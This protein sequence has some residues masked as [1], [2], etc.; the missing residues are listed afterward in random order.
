MAKLGRDRNRL[1]ILPG[2]LVVVGDTAEEA[3][4]KRAR[5]DGLVNY[6]LTVRELAQRLGG[7]A[8]LAFVGTPSTIADQMEEWLTTESL[9]RL[10]RHVPLRAAG[11]RR[12]RRQGRAGIAAARHLPTRI[13]GYNAAQ[14]SPPA[15]AGE[16]IL[17]IREAR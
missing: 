14:E 10:Q 9:R 1:K 12:F 13:R 3:R 6:N 16:P 15:P 4:E 5:V 11:P 8:G 17:P 7:Y 2:A